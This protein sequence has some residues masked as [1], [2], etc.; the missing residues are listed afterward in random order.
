[1]GTP[2]AFTWAATHLG[3]VLFFKEDVIHKVFG[4]KPANYQVTTVHARGVEDGS[5]GSLCMMN[6]TL[7]YQSRTGMVSYE[8]SLPGDIGQAFGYVKYHD[9]VAGSCD[10][11]MWVSMKDGNGQSHLFVY[12][13]GTGLWHREDGTEA[14]AF[15]AVGSDMYMATEKA[16]WLLEGSGDEDYEDQSAAAEAAVEWMAE[17]GDLDMT[18]LYKRHLQKVMLRFR[19]EEG[20]AC[21]IQASYDGGEYVTL[22]QVTTKEDLKAMTVPIVPHR[23]D[24]MRL[25]LT[26]TGWIEIMDL[27]YVV[28][29]GSEL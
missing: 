3:Y 21:A 15:R 18:N 8:G 6:E 9:A 27:N 17:T 16:L 20:A 25:K 12:G 2:G 13:A 7:Y 24:H 14:E 5:A 26:G 10:G 19:M 29:A 11:Q 23:C 4:N 1:M 22:K 28:W